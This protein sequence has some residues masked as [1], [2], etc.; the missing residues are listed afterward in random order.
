MKVKIFTRIISLLL[1]T[2]TVSL[3]VSAQTDSS[4]LSTLSLKDLLSEKVTTASK[5]LQEIGLAPATVMVVTRDQIRIRGY[6]S[7]LDVLY[8][9]P[10]VKID[11]KMYS[12]LR[13]SV[14]LRGVQGS[15]KFMVLLDGISISSPSGEA[16][17]VME[18]YPV[19]FAD[20]VEIV[21][22]PAS[23]LYGA[24]ALSG[25]IN[26]ITKKGPGKKSWVAEASALG[27][28]LGYSN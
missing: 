1:V 13:N 6:Q 2:A 28:T 11:D 4:K 8:D 17:P 24:N 7:L 15:E 23:A 10:D 26:I 21:F 25:V 3:H 22:G 18:N 27:G 5:T 14:T 16:M 12:G 20:Q 19:H 9:L